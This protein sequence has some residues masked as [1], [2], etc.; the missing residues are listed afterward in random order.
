VQIWIGLGLDVAEAFEIED[1]SKGLGADDLGG[2]GLACRLL[3]EGVA[4]D[5]ETDPAETLDIEKA[6]QKRNRELG[7]AGAGGHRDQHLAFVLGQRFL[8]L[9]DGLALKGPEREAELEGLGLE[10]CV[11]V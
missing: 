9:F 8:D 6:V 5:N 11:A 2:A 1:V 4:A 10:R 7:L 3:T